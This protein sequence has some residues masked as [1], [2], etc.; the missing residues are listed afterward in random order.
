[1]PPGPSTVQSPQGL[2]NGDPGA[3][4]HQEP[5]ASGSNTDE[6]MVDWGGAKRKMSL[7]QLAELAR[8]HESAQRK[9][10][11]A[12][13]MLQKHAAATA[14]V[15]S[16]DAM[17]PADQE[18]FKVV[19]ANPRLAR[20]LVSSPA[21]QPVDDDPFGEQEPTTRQ[22]QPGNAESQRLELLERGMKALLEEAHA[23]RGQEQQATLGQQVD[24]SMNSFEVFGENDSG[25]KFARQSIMQALAANPK[26]K[27]DDIV[28]QHAVQLHELLQA[29]RQRSTAPS[30]G[31]GELR[32][33]RQFQ[34]PNLERD[35]TMKDLES[36]RIGK[37]LLGRR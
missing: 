18:A 25:K 8:T 16:L 24:K 5:D 35:F 10:A 34:L 29:E 30:L 20:K 17:D 32:T 14:F 22:Q 3:G 15:R 36:G 19:L 6:V 33:Q 28:S 11:V 2:Q 27:V 31:G 37:M 26:A 21:Q 7:K 9:E 4:E 23:R 13:E 1:M 12:E